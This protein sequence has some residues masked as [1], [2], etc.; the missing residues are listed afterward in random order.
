M[1]YMIDPNFSAII[2][3]LAIKEIA[4]DDELKLS[5]IR[6]PSILRRLRNRLSR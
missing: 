5:R 6:K 3:S 1:L 4:N 2:A